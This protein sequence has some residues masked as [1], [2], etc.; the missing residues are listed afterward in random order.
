MTT[1]K[2]KMTFPMHPELRGLTDDQRK[3]YEQIRDLYRSHCLEQ[4]TKRHQIGRLVRQAR[5]AMR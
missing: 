5:T 4:A 1:K 3:L 2:T